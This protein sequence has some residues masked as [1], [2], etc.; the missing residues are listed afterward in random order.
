MGV[1]GLSE[2]VWQSAR[3]CLSELTSL[4]GLSALIPAAKFP[5]AVYFAS[6]GKVNL[7]HWYISLVHGYIST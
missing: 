7:L 4:V 6:Q 3:R 2:M 5:A 1:L